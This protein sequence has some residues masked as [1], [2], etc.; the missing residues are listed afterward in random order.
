MKRLVSILLAL[1]LVSSMVLAQQEAQDPRMR[2][3]VQATGEE[4]PEPM[5]ISAQVQTRERAQTTE[6]LR[7]MVQQRQQVMAQEMQG[8]DEAEQKVYQ[9]QNRVREA[10]HSFLAMEDLVGGIGPQVREIARN[11][12]NS[13]QATIRAEQRIERR[14]AVARFF[15][16]GDE[17]AAAEIEERVNQNQ[18]R[19]QQLKQLREE[20][21][22][23]AEVKELMRAQIQNMEQEQTRL[24][25]LA[26]R[27]KGSKGL[28]G[29]LWK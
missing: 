15:A 25:E 10:V 27:E 17:E 24:N 1:V 28:F 9:N 26:Q 11:F 18:E 5:L 14:S 3:A 29:W 2:Q 4:A 21:D 12:N 19:I 22:C 16:G 7:Q 20:C 23:G 8:M 13:V 6:Q